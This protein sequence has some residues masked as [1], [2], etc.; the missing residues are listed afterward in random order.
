MIISFDTETTG[1]TERSAPFTDPRQPWPVTLAGILAEELDGGVLKIVDQAYVVVKLPA[2]TLIHPKAQEVHGFSWERTQDEG[3]DPREA[4][5]V[6]QKL[7]HRASAHNAYNLE[8]DDKVMKAFAYR[9]MLLDGMTD[10]DIA[11]L[12]LQARF[13]GPTAVEDF[14]AKQLYGH[15]NGVPSDPICSMNLAT[16]F[17]KVPGRG[18]V[19]GGGW[20]RHKLED[21]HRRLTGLP[22][23]DAH[24]A[25]ADAHGAHNVLAAML[26]A[27]V[28]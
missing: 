3:V 24:N 27:T 25:L 6:F 21:A 28:V 2:G 9:C 22:L 19:D 8:F 26:K 12:A 10:K 20:R 4:L 14:I 11:T 7:A 23:P 16:N 1:L 18:F 15:Q 5:T 13:T 17:L